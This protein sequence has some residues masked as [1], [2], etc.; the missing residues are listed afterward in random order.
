MK[1][2]VPLASVLLLC[3]KCEEEIGF[4]KKHG[5]KE[6]E[7]KWM[8]VWLVYEYEKGILLTLANSCWVILISF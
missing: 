5:R 8:T 7:L 6:N 4:S 2:G 3:G 1:C